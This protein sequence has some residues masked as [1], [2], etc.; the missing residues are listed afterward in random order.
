MITNITV[1][2]G[3]ELWLG[4][5]NARGWLRPNGDWRLAAPDDVL[6]EQYDWISGNAEQ[7]YDEHLQMLQAWRER[8]MP[9]G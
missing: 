8:G 7:H 5:A 4:E 9:S 1:T 3:A 6:R 2:T